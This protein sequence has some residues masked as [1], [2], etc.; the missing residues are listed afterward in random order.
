MVYVIPMLAGV[1]AVWGVFILVLSGDNRVVIPMIVR[2]S[3]AMQK[4]NVAMTV[5]M[6]ALTASMLDAQRATR[7]LARAI[8]S[9]SVASRRRPSPD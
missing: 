1:V 9:G 8:R 7:N 6:K 4:F 3:E 2:F 5:A